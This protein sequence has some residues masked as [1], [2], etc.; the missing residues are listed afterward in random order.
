MSFSALLQTVHASTGDLDTTSPS[1][2]SS[3]K[4]N[5]KFALSTSRATATPSV[6]Q[7]LQPA[8][9]LN[10][11]ELCIQE[12]GWDSF[13]RLWRYWFK[14]AKCYTESKDPQLVR[15]TCGR[16][17]QYFGL[18]RPVTHPMPDKDIFPRCPE[19]TICQPVILINKGEGGPLERAGCVALKDIVKETVRSDPLAE[20]QK[21]HCGLSLQL[22]GPYYIGVPGE[23]KINVVLTEQVQYL[24]G[25]SYP[26]PLLYIRDTSNSQSIDRA[27]RQHA[28]VAST[29]IELGIYR[30]H[31]VS[32]NFEF[33]MQMLPGH[34]ISSVIFTYSFFNVFLQHS[35][36]PYIEEKAGQT[37]ESR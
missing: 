37:F 31:F 26:A 20:N 25:S 5:R 7:T 2:L 24:D 15:L 22:P 28:S 32:K 36:I 4:Q 35:R 6:S 30:G 29:V 18:S 21:V 17:Y 16:F 12:G 34:T 8:Q 23:Q 11:E 1:F 33:C 13:R 19:G 9:E 3:P 10:Y 14:D 27:W